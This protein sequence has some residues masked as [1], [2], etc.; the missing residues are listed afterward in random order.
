M[1]RAHF[2]CVKSFTLSNYSN[3]KPDEKP[4]VCTG[5]LFKQ[6]LFIQMKFCCCN[7]LIAFHST[8]KEWRGFVQDK[9]QYIQNKVQ[10][11]QPLNINSRTKLITK[12]QTQAQ[13]ITYC[14]LFECLSV[15]FC[16]MFK[17]AEQ[18]NKSADL[19]WGHCSVSSNPFFFFVQDSAC[20]EGV[21][22]YSS[23]TVRQKW[24]GWDDR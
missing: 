7:E 11:I 15:L 20:D 24:P 4:T 1:F 8:F 16:E 18:I 17:K 14:L 19:S 13:I 5:V 9:I 10:Y 23:W 21:S 2:H 12:Q 3:Y 6:T 22:H